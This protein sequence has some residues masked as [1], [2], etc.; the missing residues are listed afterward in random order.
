MN[1]SADLASSSP[2]SIS[3]S[4]PLFMKSEGDFAIR[5]ERSRPHSCRYSPVSR[6]M[7][8]FDFGLISPPS[9]M[10][11]AWHDMILTTS[12]DSSRRSVDS[13]ACL[14]ES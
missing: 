13:L 14:Y 11:L 5:S 10:P 7:N 8:L 4:F 6:R 2:T 12:L 3:A 9:G 1:A